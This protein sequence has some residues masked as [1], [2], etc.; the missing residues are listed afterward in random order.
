MTGNIKAYWQNFIGGEWCDGA[1][2]ETIPVENPANGERIAEVARAVPADVDRAVAAARKVFESRVLWDM[3]PSERG[4]MLFE[5]A[6][7]LTAMTEEIALLECLDNGKTIANG[8]NE[9]ALTARYL[10]YYGGMADKLEGRQ[11][12]LGKDYLDYTVHTPF[13]VSAQIVP[14]NGPMPV[15]ARSICCAFVTGNTVVLKSPEDSPLSLFKLAEACERAGVP[16]G[17]INIICG[18][19]HDAGAALAAHGD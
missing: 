16:K 2:G 8:R 14:F 5:V 17:A 7:Q 18:Y 13:G 9:V 11:I 12:P 15:G 3:R 19:G 1:T 6:R 4:E 10:T